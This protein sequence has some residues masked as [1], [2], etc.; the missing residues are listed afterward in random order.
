MAMWSSLVIGPSVGD[1]VL[2]KSTPNGRWVRA[3]I[4][5]IRSAN[6]GGGSGATPSTP[7]PPASETAATSSGNATNPMPAPTNACRRPN[8]S[9]SRVRIS[10]SGDRS[11]PCAFPGRAPKANAIPLAPTT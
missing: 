6:A 3:R 8:L 1:V 9:V 7:R 10:G 4:C 5:A 2:K 11:S